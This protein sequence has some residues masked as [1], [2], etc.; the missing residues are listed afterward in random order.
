MKTWRL[1][2]GILCIVLSVFVFFQ[3]NMAGFVI[4][5]QNSNDTGAGAGII[6]AALLLAG[7]ITSIA[8]RNKITTGSKIALAILFALAAL[9]AMTNAKVYGDLM[10]WGIWA[11]I[12]A[13]LALFGKK[14]A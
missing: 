3:S 1:V 11:A 13:V 2:A 10:V 5:V 8:T 9:I 6:V 4:A 7:G 14:S 12:N